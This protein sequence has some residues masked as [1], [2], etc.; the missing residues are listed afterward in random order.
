MI[1][2][3]THARGRVLCDAYHYYHHGGGAYRGPIVRGMTTNECGLPFCDRTRYA[4]DLCQ[5]HYVYSREGK[6]LKELRSRGE[7]PS[8]NTAG[9]VRVGGTYAHRLVM[10]GIMGRE[11]LPHESVHHRNGDRSDNRPEN[12]ELWYR[13]Q[14]AGQRVEDLI[15]YLVKHHRPAIE[16]ALKN[17]SP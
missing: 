8:P 6:P 14:P 16:E 9:Y 7:T 1:I 15:A 13:S 10:T 5:T 11:L 17:E 12:L 3:A 2:C 4:K